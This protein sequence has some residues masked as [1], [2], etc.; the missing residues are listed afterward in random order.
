[1]SGHPDQ[2]FGGKTYAQTGEDLMICNLFE[3]MGIK[4]PS[5][6]DVGAH[7]PWNISN[8]ALLYKRGS[9]GV[10]VEAN[11]NLLE[12]FRT[13]RPEDLNL[14]T[15]VGSKAGTMPFYMFDEKSG[16]NTFDKQ[17]ADQFALDYP[18]FYIREIKQIPVVTLNTLVDEHCP[19]GFPN[20]LSIDV[21]GLDY[22]ILRGTDLGKSP[23]AIICVE[24]STPSIANVISEV[25]WSWEY[26]RLCKMGLNLIFI[27]DTYAEVAR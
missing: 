5:Y 2:W 12:E 3:L 14:C 25:L 16:R 24:A 4:K 19:G 23:P 17:V 15:G 20:L 27:Q 18:Q 11:P 8:T 9:R 26:I 1:M 21:E 22:D 7:H 10:N 13:A 6:L